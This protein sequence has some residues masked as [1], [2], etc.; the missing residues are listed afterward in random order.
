MRRSFIL[1]TVLAGLISGDLLARQGVRVEVDA[2]LQ[3][4]RFTAADIA[5]FHNGEV[6]A[7]AEST[8]SEGELATVA[9]VRINASRDQVASYYGQMVS[10]VDGEVTLAFGKFSTP[11]AP[12]DVARLALDAED[13]QTLRA[14]KPGN[15]DMRLGSAGLEGMQ[16][17]IDWSSPRAV[18]QVNAYAR[19]AA[20]D[21]V[22]AYQQRGDAA[23]VTHDDRSKP[24]S[25]G[26][27]WKGLLANAG[28]LGEYVPEL[29]DYLAGYPGK[30][31][32]GARDIFYWAKENYG[33]KPVIS[34]V[35]AVV[36]ERPS[37]PDRLYVVQKQLY[38]DHY[39][40]GSLAV[41]TVLSSTEGGRPVSYLLYSNRSRGDMLK[42]G[43]G[44]LKRTVARDQASKAAEDTLGTIKQ[45]L[46]QAR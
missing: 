2:F 43:F 32:A 10:Y 31:V 9:A 21:Y 29:R 36:Y 26:V 44:G 24:V 41:A 7:R 45:V 33:R 16:R 19:K 37:P 13:V 25:L 40:D 34:L 17:A 15:C 22:T 18:E 6:I 28:L 38:A 42:G 3:R 4:V 1:A 46:E 12:A 20:I 8:S 5:R 39:F 11:P 30:T 35:H 23:L 14:C 27:Q